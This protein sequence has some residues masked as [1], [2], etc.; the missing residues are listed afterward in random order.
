MPR[1]RRGP[2]P[3]R[4]AVARAGAQRHQQVHV[5]RERLGRMPAR[6]VEAR[7]QDELHRRGQQELRPGRQHPVLAEQVPQHGQHQR[8]RQQQAHGHGREAGPGA[9]G[10]GLGLLRGQRARLVARVAHGAP[11]Q[12]VHVRAGGVV[13]H[14]H[15]LGGQVHRRVLHAGH[16]AQRALHAGHAARAG[17]AAHA[18][19]Q[20]GG[21]VLSR[22]RHGETSAFF[23]MAP[24]LNLAM[25]A[26]S[27]PPSLQIRLTLPPW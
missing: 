16:L 2:Q 3:Q 26:R 24:S 13:G 21:G 11:G 17:H 15:R 25:L 22:R 23:T 1:V 14:V 6:L 18:E 12:R 7:A 27:T 19:I 10:V 8:R 5:A 4:Q 20:R 9:G